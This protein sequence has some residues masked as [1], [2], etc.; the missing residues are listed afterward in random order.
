MTLVEVKDLHVL[1]LLLSATFDI[2]FFC[3]AKLVLETAEGCPP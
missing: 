3:A 2:H 1:S